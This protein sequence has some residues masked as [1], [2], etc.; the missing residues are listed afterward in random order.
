MPAKALWLMAPYATN[1]KVK[2]NAVQK[3][4]VTASTLSEPVVLCGGLMANLA[5][6]PSFRP[7]NSKGMV[8]AHMICHGKHR[9]VFGPIVEAVPVDMVDVLSFRQWSSK[10]TSHD[11]A[12][13]IAPSVSTE[14]AFNQVIFAS[15]ATHDAF[16]TDWA[17]V[18]YSTRKCLHSFAPVFRSMPRDEMQVS[19]DVSMSIKLNRCEFPASTTTWVLATQAL[20]FSHA[21]KDTYQ[22][23]GVK[24]RLS[25]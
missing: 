10:D 13:L 21:A 22:N 20:P 23:G 5:F 18:I 8:V 3:A 11:N 4:L 15:P 16:R 17:P 19:V 2:R 1:R 6:R 7:A 24:C 25:V 14:S 12:M 9:K